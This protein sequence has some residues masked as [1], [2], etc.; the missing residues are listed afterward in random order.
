MGALRAR[1]ACDLAVKTFWHAGCSILGEQSFGDEPAMDTE[2][3]EA[4]A[5]EV[6]TTPAQSLRVAVASR[7]GVRIN[8]H[9]GA[10][11][12]F[13]VFDV[14]AEGPALVGCRDVPSHA[15]PGDETERDTICRM[16]ADCKVLL[17]EKV[18][19][20]PQEKL[21]GVGIEATNLYAGK[22]IEAALLQ[23]FATKCAPPSEIDASGF[24][25][26]HTM[27]RVAD[28]DRSIDFYTGFLGMQVLERRDHKKNQ[29]SQ[30][31][32]G[33]GG[34]SSQMV[35]ELVSN[36]TREE[37]YT[38]GDSFGHIAIQV[39]GIAALC[40][41]LAA[42]G[43]PMPRPPSTQRHGSN[44]VAFIE[45]PDGHRIELVQFPAS[46]Q[47]TEASPTQH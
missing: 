38:V 27:L 25:L 15:K 46:Q 43:T 8:L 32:L 12:E 9:F 44:I 4:S 31:Y 30:A 34:D 13:L 23:L 5:P 21:A 1:L 20:A 26:A 47:D 17:V 2:T 40:E 45:D 24:R 14:T 28:L 3:L 7:D 37:P 29:F 19:A 11:E 22:P 39:S 6:R 35:L 36:W 10:A 33:Y 41:R 42:A 16:L 18:G